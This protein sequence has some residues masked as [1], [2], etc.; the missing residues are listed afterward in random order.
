MT[1][2]STTTNFWTPQ[3]LGSE[4]VHPY[5]VTYYSY[6]SFG[7]DGV[8]HT[9]IVAE[10]YVRTLNLK[11]TS[12]EVRF[13]NDGNGNLV[14]IIGD[15]EFEIPDFEDGR[16]ITGF[17]LIGSTIDA[18]ISIDGATSTV[19]IGQ[20]SLTVTANAATQT[21]SL[22]LPTIVGTYFLENVLYSDGTSVN[23]RR[24]CFDRRHCIR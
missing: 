3:A 9:T 23:M 20:G 16:V 11:A 18:D 1:A 8:S 13:N 2:F 4:T 12:D 6:E 22:G 14:V 5:I 7:D 15:D 21:N 17:A 19:S 10:T 24:R